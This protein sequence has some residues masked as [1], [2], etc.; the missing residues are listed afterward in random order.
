MSCI[1]LYDIDMW[2]KGKSH[3]NLELMKTFNYLQQENHRVIMMKPT[4]E[5]GRFN[6][7]IY[8]KDNINVDIPR[9]INV[10]G[11]NKS[12]YGFGF[13][14]YMTP[15]NPNVVPVPPSYLPYDAYSNKVS[16]PVSYDTLKKNSLIRFET[17]DFTDLKAD[18][19]RIC[20]A[21]H[22]ILYLD[23]VE[24][25]IQEY[26]NKTFDFYYTPVA[27]DAETAIRFMRYSAIFS[28]PLLIDF[29]YDEDFFYENFR[30]NILFK[31]EKR[32][33]ETKENF[34][35]RHIKISLWYKKNKVTYR[36]P[37]FVSS[38]KGFGK[39]IFDWI[40]YN[41]PVSYYEYYKDNKEAIKFAEGSITELRLMLKIKPENVTKENL[42]LQKNL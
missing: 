35:L 18:C 26:K 28:K 29:K 30:E 32:E 16:C 3:P 6:Q 41:S 36:N 1:G 7:I 37:Y 21:D 42:N 4:D 8:F 17:K 9:T 40:M 33:N 31:I 27:K 34:Y 20:F 25:F 38:E 22:N 13:Y 10:T 39:Y 11:E 24:D 19:K 14:G 15:L 2:H 5:V 12:F 23:G